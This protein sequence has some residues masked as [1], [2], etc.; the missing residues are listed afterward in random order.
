MKDNVNSAIDFCCTS[1][2]VNMDYAAKLHR[3][4]N[5]C[6]PSVCKSVGDFEGGRLGYFADDDNTIE[7]PR[8]KA[9]HKK[10]A[11]YLDVKSDFQLFDGNR[12]HWVEP[13]EGERLSF[14]FFCVSKYWKAKRDVLA[15]L[16][17]RGFALPTSEWLSHS[18]SLLSQ[19]RGYGSHQLPRMASLADM[20]GQPPP[21]R[22]R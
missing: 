1:I 10:D 14:V 2:S 16:E 7:L 22:G 11:V 4:S 5:N 9:D 3:D 18:E 6:G 15:Q 17:A 21:P 13:F 20:F 12:A 19:P 8:L